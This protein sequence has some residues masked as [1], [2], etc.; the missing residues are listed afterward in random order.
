MVFAYPSVMAFGWKPGRV[1]SL[2]D[3]TWIHAPSVIPKYKLLD[4]TR[5]ESNRVNDKIYLTC[6]HVVMS[7]VLTQH[8]CMSSIR[9][10]GTHHFLRVRQTSF[11]KKP[12]GERDPLLPHFFTL[13]MRK[14]VNP[15]NGQSISIGGDDAYLLEHGF[16]EG[17]FLTMWYMTARYVVPPRPLAL[18]W[19]TI[20]TA[21]RLRTTRPYCCSREPIISATCLDWLR[22]LT[23]ASA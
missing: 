20:D 19:F 11:L 9:D 14:A 5:S 22:C 18:E 21:L 16:V 4:S 3:Q 7:P 10:I 2:W 17:T 6:N 12:L 8:I 23:F 15:T 1:D 13:G